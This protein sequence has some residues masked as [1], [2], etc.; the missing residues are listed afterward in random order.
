MSTSDRN[1]TGRSGI[2]T[3]GL[4]PSGITRFAIL[5]RRAFGRRC[6]YCGAPGIFKGWFELRDHC[7]NCGVSFE[8]EEGYFLGAMLVNLLVAEGITVAIVAILMVYAKLE[9]LPLE[10]V[11]IVFAVGL[12]ILFFP[13]SRTLWMAV[14]I[15]LDPPE[16]QTERRLR[17]HD[18][19]R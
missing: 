10:I 7:P 13:F 6:P 1:S 18:M 17:G 11:A 5:L 8:R 2:P 16:L 19:R 12:P 15:A 14:D 3:Q 4:P 9:L